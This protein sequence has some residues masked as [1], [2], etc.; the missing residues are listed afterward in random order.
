L[1]K[2]LQKEEGI[3][4]NKSTSFKKKI[5]ELEKCSLGNSWS[6]EQRAGFNSIKIQKDIEDLDTNL[7][8]C[9]EEERVFVK[10]QSTL[11]KS[12]TKDTVVISGWNVNTKG[13]KSCEFDFLIV[14]E[15]LKTIFQI[16]VKRTHSQKSRK[17]AREQLQKGKQLFE[18]K[19]IFPNKE[20]W[21]YAKVMYFALNEQKED[22]K[23]SD[24]HFCQNCQSFIL[25]PATD[26]TVWWG[27]ITSYLFQWESQSSLTPLNRNIYNQTVQFLTHQMYIQGD[28]FTNQHLLDHTEE[29]I[30][31]ISTPE[32]LFFWSKAQ[33]LLYNDSRN[34]RMVFIS[35]FGT[36][37]TTLLKSMSRRLLENGEKVTFIF[38][39]NES[40]L[41][42]TYFEEFKIFN[43]NQ[44]QILNLKCKGKQFK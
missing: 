31:K 25:G 40:L 34:K 7:A 9:E 33:Y 2:G 39:E 19:F 24:F 44:V 21:K 28:C 12:N 38:W 8:G 41:Q 1:F 20:N 13:Q 5:Q 22:F 3:L 36:G 27:Q 32:K 43:E 10:L 11:E 29:K 6:G 15:P 4:G 42:K 35:P 18:S 30:E 26:L 23:S 14:S 37:K 17:S 16:E